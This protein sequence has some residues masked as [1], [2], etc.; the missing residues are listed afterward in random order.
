[1]VAINSRKIKDCITRFLIYMCASFSVVLLVGIITYVLIKG[2]PYV[3]L[4]FLIS[5][6]SV[7]K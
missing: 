4:S 2:L 7:L 3:S 1:M 6:T 5:V